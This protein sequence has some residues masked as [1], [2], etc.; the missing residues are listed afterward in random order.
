M[1]V[2]RA[3]T[4]YRSHNSRPSVITTTV[5]ELPTA[6][7]TASAT[8][9]SGMLSRQVMMNITTSSIR[10]PKKPPSTPSVMPITPLVSAATTPISSE[11]RAP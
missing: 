6:D 5:N 9:I 10:P 11:I 4:A 2:V 3:T 8:R 1:V 7:T